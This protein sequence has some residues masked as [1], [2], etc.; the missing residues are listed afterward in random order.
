MKVNDIKALSY[1]IGVMMAV[2]K[3]NEHMQLD[4][5]VGAMLI[6]VGSENLDKNALYDGIKN[7]IEN[8]TSLFDNLSFDALNELEE[9]FNDILE[10]FK[11]DLD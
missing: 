9:C 4:D 6:A 11:D 10:Y 8:Q 7:E 1:E 2:A 5:C 3:M